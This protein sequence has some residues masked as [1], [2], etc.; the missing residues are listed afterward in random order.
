MIND[1]G[2]PNVSND[3]TVNRSSTPQEIKIKERTY[4][5]FFHSWGVCTHHDTFSFTTLFIRLPFNCTLAIGEAARKMATIQQQPIQQAP[6]SQSFEAVPLR[7]LKLY[8][9]PV[10][11][12]LC[13]KRARTQTCTKLTPNHG[14]GDI[15]MAVCLSTF[16]GVATV[17]KK[18]V[19]H[20]CSSCG[21]LLVKY[22]P[23]LQPSNRGHVRRTMQPEGGTKVIAYAQNLPI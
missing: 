21:G 5:A 11:C 20:T 10:D 18:W 22:H 1:Y 23:G 19:E 15:L 2:F 12:P 14:S 9:A 13:G 8:A 4:I 16:C 6:P 7:E 17:R 3:P